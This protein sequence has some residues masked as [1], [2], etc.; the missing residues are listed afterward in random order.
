MPPRQHSWSFD[1]YKQGRHEVLKGREKKADQ[2]GTWGQRRN[3]AAS[4][5]GIFV[6]QI[7][8]LDPGNRASEDH[9]G[10]RQ[11]KKSHQK[12]FSVGKGPG[13][14]QCSKNLTRQKTQ[15]PTAHTRLPQKRPR[16]GDWTSM[17]PWLSG[18]CWGPSP[19]RPAVLILPPFYRVSGGIRRPWT[20]TPPRG[21][22]APPPHRARARLLLQAR[23]GPAK[24]S[25]GPV[26]HLI[27]QKQHPPKEAK[28]GNLCYFSS[29]KAAP[30]WNG[31]WLQGYFQ[32]L[33]KL[34]SCV[35]TFPYVC[36]I[37]NKRVK[38]FYISML[39]I[40]QR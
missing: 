1:Y 15:K 14:Q 3:S 36:F 37:H 28:W 20:C 4:S 12:P 35:C 10:Y 29:N 23:V 32:E 11:K 8:E 34:Y 13:K 25:G 31:M 30:S 21:N 17:S 9:Q 33:V 2:P 26:P 5:L 22:G 7:P 6:S 40:P 19:P 18:H 38:Y 27:Q 16:G 39:G 24:A